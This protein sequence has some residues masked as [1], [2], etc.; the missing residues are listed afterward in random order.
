[1]RSRLVFAAIIVAGAAPALAQQRAMTSADYARAERYMGYN[2]MP[3]VFDNAVRPSWLTNERFWYRNVTPK[4]VEFV[5]VD[6]TR[7][8]RTDLLAEPALAS[9]IAAATQATPDAMRQASTQFDFAADG[10][11]I[12][13]TVG[14]RTV[15]CDVET[16]R[17]GAAVDDR[18]RANAGGR[19]GRGGRGGGRGGRGGST[20]APETLSPDGKRAAFIRDWNLWMRDVATNREIQLTHRWRQGLRLRHRQR[21]LD[22]QRPRDSGLVARLE[23]D[24]HVPAGSAQRR[25]DVSRQHAGRASGAASVEVSAAGDSVITDDPARHH[26]RQR[27][28]AT[29]DSPADAARSASLDALRPHRVPWRRLGGRR[30]VS[31]TARISPSSRRRAITSTRCFASP[32]RAPAPFA[33]CSRKRSQ[34][35]F[36]SGNGRVNW[37]VLPASNE[38]IWF[39]ER[40]NW[41][42]L[43][44]YDL[45]TGKLEAPDHDRRRQRHAARCAS[46]RRARMLYFSG[47]RQGER[48]A[49]RTSDTSTRSG[50]TERVSTLLTPEDAD[51]DVS[52]SPIGQVFRRHAIRVPMCRRRPSCA[53]RTA[54]CSSRSRRPTSRACSRRD[55]SRPC[56][57]R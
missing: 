12:N 36:E 40:D 28:R 35:Q 5:V 25:R 18:E 52:L 17:C 22:E 27:R 10:R 30:V 23:E 46:T 41:G 34:T 43:Y 3:L 37:H 26:R 16:S 9:A 6:P 42:Q 49:I 54:R 13:V 4:G 44:L 48:A 2:T 20:R 8:T 39:S 14:G 24:R 19:G 53:T 38:V 51:H 11:M 1:M 15:S 45:T 47:R 50:W 29:H 32:T 21:R 33:T 56:R 57:S 31:R 7:K 55:G